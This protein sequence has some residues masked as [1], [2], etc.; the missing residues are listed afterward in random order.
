MS[1]YQPVS[2]RGTVLYFVIADLA[3]IDPMYQ[4]SLNYFSNLYNQIIDNC[5]TQVDRIQTLIKNITLVIFE[6][7]CRGLFNNHKRIFSF[8]IT[9]KI[10]ILEH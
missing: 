6:N 8:L 5:E 1:M 10:I 4:F 3:L 7:I 2:Q 9:A